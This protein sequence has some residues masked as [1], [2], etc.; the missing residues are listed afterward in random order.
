MRTPRT[1]IVRIVSCMA[2]CTGVAALSVC[3]A[4]G[5]AN[6]DAATWTLPSVQIDFF[7]EP[8]CS[9][10]QRIRTEV[11]PSLQEAYGGFYVLTEY[12]LG[13]KSNYLQLVGYMEA[14]GD[15][16]NARVFMVVDRQVLLGGGDEIAADLFAVL[17]ERISMA[18]ERPE[19]SS[20]GLVP[21]PVVPADDAIV[22]RR[23]NR[24][25]FV[26]VALAGLVDGINPCAIST[27]VFLVSVLSMARV[28]GRHL[29]AVGAAFC[30]A[31]FLTYLAIGFGM[32]HAFHALAAFQTLRRVI[33][34]F[35][36]A[37]L[38][39]LALYSFGDAFRFRRTHRASDVKLQLPDAFKQRIHRL[40][41]VG[42]GRRAQWA[43][44]FGIAVAVTALESVCTG[45]V[46]V[47]T[48]ALIIKGD[49]EVTRGLGLLVLYN[50]M[51]ILPLVVVLLLTYG[52]LQLGRLMAWSVKEVFI[53]KL[54]LAVLFLLLA[55]L[56]LAL[57]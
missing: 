57:G 48:L 55:V 25:T 46:Y 51:F 21:A 38:L 8:G 35:L 4:P 31:S 44:V 41:R 16:E 10:C 43:S 42:L 14:L 53:G 2:L 23:F 27:L 34:L 9:E 19:A 3:P 45:Q 30:S 54:L 7:Y 13:V 32:L 17:D 12:D 22:E 33:D 15:D 6:E 47:P 20:S 24:F 26:G 37:A 11:L 28:R 49:S 1:S 40:L 36:V 52:G 18:Q 56:T 39:G 29:L 5:A 50:A